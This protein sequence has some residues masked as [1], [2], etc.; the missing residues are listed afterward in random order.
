MIQFNCFYKFQKELKLKN[1][2]FEKCFFFCISLTWN[3]MKRRKYKPEKLGIQ[4][5]LYQT[6]GL[7]K[8]FFLEMTGM[9]V[10]TAA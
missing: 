5:S 9:Y 7:W 10:S 1:N 8:I 3:N 4:F 6:G 2:Q